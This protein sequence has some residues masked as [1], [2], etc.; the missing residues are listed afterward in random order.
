MIDTV[1]GWGQSVGTTDLSPVLR[2][3]CFGVS[4]ALQGYKEGR[5]GQ[6]HTQ[7]GSDGGQE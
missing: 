7:E 5:G 1:S 3:R 4:S 6:T 2:A